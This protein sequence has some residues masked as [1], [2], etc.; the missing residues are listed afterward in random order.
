M[1]S[2]TRQPQGP[3]R[4]LGISGKDALEFLFTIF[5]SHEY[6]HPLPLA[7][8]RLLNFFFWRSLN[9]GF[10]SF[11]DFIQQS[12]PRSHGVFA[13]QPLMT[14]AGLILVNLTPKRKRRIGVLCKLKYRHLHYARWLLLAKNQLL[15]SFDG[16]R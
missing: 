2:T 5:L 14:K 4:D 13:A 7:L 16:F 9:L 15:D 11:I 12:M 6:L 1:S 8:T 10:D 3:Y